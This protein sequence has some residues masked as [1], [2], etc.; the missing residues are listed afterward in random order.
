MA[1]RSNRDDFESPRV[2]PI[3]NNFAESTGIFGGLIPLRNFVEG[4][5]LALPMFLIAC[6]IPNVELNTRIPLIIFMGSPGLIFGCVGING[7]SVTEFLLYYIRY[8]KHRRVA[9]YNPRVK[10][11]F[12]GE[13]D[14]GL[15][16]PPIEQVKRMMTNL[17]RKDRE[18]VSE[19]DIYYSVGSNVAFE[20]DVALKKKLAAQA[21]R[22]GRNGRKKSSQGRR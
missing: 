4:V 15:F 9:R 16:E 1:S 7:D 13:L 6:S 12:I 19:S 3:P 11:E 18:D 21:E 17:G 2:Y 10:L 5:V 22:S 20:D 8:R 14:I